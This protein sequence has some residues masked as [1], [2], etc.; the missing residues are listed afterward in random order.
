MVGKWGVKIKNN[1]WRAQ[2]NAYG[3]RTDQLEHQPE[4]LSQ[5]ALEWKIVLGKCFQSYAA[6]LQENAKI[7]R[8][9]KD[10]AIMA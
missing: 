9:T 2:Q 10:E 8:K 1:R 6:S 5:K 4:D 7:I 3:L